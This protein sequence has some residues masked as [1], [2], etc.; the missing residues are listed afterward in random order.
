[1][2]RLT[3][4]MPTR[5]FMDDF[6]EVWLETVMARERDYRSTLCRV[7]IAVAIAAPMVVSGLVVGP[8]APLEGAPPRVVLYTG[9]APVMRMLPLFLTTV[10]FLGWPMGQ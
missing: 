4:G 6:D 3:Q 7:A 8:G 2:D 9:K 5:G 10:V 1:M